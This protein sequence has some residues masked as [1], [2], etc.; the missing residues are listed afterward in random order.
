MVARVT[1][2]RECVA[3]IKDSNF[4]KFVCNSIRGDKEIYILLLAHY[5]HIRSTRSRTVDVFS[6]SIGRWL[7]T[8]SGAER[9][10]IYAGS[11]AF[12]THF[13]FFRTK[14]KATFVLFHPVRFYVLHR[15]RRQFV[16]FA[17][18]SW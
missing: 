1:T 4:S 2:F 12:S 10:P 17:P 11:Y 6:C 13:T 9:C 18:I 3:Q 5:S 8:V 16:I 7:Y 14:N 15:R